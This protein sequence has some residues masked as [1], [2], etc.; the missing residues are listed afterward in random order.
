MKKT[1]ENYKKEY[2][3]E[4]I[5]A[6]KL[7]GQEKIKIQT[8]NGLREIGLWE[9]SKLYEYPYLY[10]I[11]YGDMLDLKAPEIMWEYFLEKYEEDDYKYHKEFNILDLAAGCGLLGKTIYENYPKNATIKNI[12]ANDI[13]ED[14]K[15]ACDRD[16]KKYY[17]HY[18]CEDI[19]SISE[20]RLTE[21][22]LFNLNV[23]FIVS[24]TGGGD[25]TQTDYKDVS[26][27][28]YERLWNIMEPHSY[29][30]FNIREKRTPGQE[31][32]MEYMSK[33]CKLLGNKLYVHRKLANGGTVNFEIIVMK[34]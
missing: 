2:N 17:K 19:E 4:L 7:Q 6:G 8:P 30:V 20:Y 11:V 27:D 25:K 16:Y 24:A 29:F 13:S 26:L 5:P 18:I 15:R 28:L 31:A 32:I 10:E 23:V 1:K 14:A 22:E 3:I 34:K 9:Y 21:Y 12:I 33:Q